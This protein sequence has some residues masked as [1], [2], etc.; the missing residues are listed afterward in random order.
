MSSFSRGTK[1][2]FAKPTDSEEASAVMVVIEDRGDRVVVSDLDHFTHFA[3]V[4]Q[5]VYATS[6]IVEVA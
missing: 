3:I 6:D 1:V 4:P 2:K 5:S